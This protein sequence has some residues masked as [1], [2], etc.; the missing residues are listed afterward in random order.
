MGASPKPVLTWGCL[1][2]NPLQPG[3]TKPTCPLAFLVVQ[4]LELH[5]ISSALGQIDEGQDAA[6]SDLEAALVAI[7][8]IWRP[9]IQL[10][11]GHFVGHLDELLPVEER[12]RF[13]GELSKY[14]QAHAEPSFLT[15][16]FT[17]YNLPADDRAALIAGMPA[18][19]TE[20]LIPV[21]WK[22]KWAP[23]QPFFLP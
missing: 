15:V 1:H 8:A 3:A 6:L 19:L 23:M 20:K 13:A 11:E 18:E 22:E 4:Y 10:E 21:V 5:R 7:E 14:G 16:P 12:F 2:S 17:L 9:H